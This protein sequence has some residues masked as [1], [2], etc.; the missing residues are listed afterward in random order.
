MAGVFSLR[1]TPDP[2]ASAVNPAYRRVV[3]AVYATGS[4]E[5]VTGAEVSPQSPV[6]LTRLLVA[7]GDTVAEGQ[8]LAE[9]DDS[10]ERA[11]LAEYEALILQHENDLKRLRPLSGKGFSSKEALERAETGL[12]EAQA[13]AEGQRRLIERMQLVSPVDGIVLRRD[14]EAGEVKQ[15]G[16]AVFWIGAPSPLRIRAEVDE[17]DILR[18]KPGQRVLIGSDALPGA[19]IEGTLSSVTPK[20]DPV[21]KS[22]R[23]YVSFPEGGQPLKTGMTVEINIVTDV[24]ERVLTVPSNA[25]FAGHVM[26]MSGK[27]AMRVPVTTGQAGADV[28]EIVSGVSEN[29]LVLSPYRE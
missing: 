6:R 15:A 9:I 23:V 3:E 4:V 2:A 19:A 16:A 27:K 18:V 13:R 21:N 22:F 7:E 12:A 11:R 26:K 25:V 24:R 8:P 10:V 5:P 20:G 1:A 28:T 29:D 17:E 14:G